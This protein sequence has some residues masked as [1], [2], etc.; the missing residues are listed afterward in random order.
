L[1]LVIAVVAWSVVSFYVNPEDEK[2]VL[3]IPV[4][5]I[6]D[7]ALA[8]RD[9]MLVGGDTT[10]GV[11]FAGRI[12][13]LANINRNTVRAEVDVRNLSTTGD[14][15]MSFVLRGDGVDLLSH[16]PLQDNVT[17]TVDRRERKFVNLRLDFTGEVAEGFM[18]DPAVFYPAN[19]EVT[20]PSRELETIHEAV[21]R[22]VPAEPLSRSVIDLPVG[23]DFFTADE[24]LVDSDFITADHPDVRLTIP[25]IMIKTVPLVVDLV[26]GGGLSTDNVY[27]EIEPRSVRI[28]GDPDVLALINFI[29]VAQINLAPLQDDWVYTYVIH[30]PEG[31]RN[32]DYFDEARVSL[33]FNVPTRE[34]QTTNITV[35][36][37]LPDGLTYILITNPVT[38]TLRGPEE[39]LDRVEP[40][41]VRVLVDFSDMEIASVGRQRR[42][43]SVFVDGTDTV[44][45]IDM[46]YE[47]TVEIV[48]MPEMPQ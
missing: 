19:L 5:I 31:V 43:A 40:S 16:Y 8:S 23:Y 34:I 35:H 21:V 11:R 32:L 9:L 29:Q 20:G 48:P 41:N 4:D 17:V 37:N 47:V 10:V 42:P 6:N 26:A 12:R 33:T 18:R 7:S 45:A 14:I 44:G 28:A 2:V 39:D 24:T 38:V 3:D 13:D 46:G 1:S 30:Y 22:Y 15:L 27:D 36:V 25:V